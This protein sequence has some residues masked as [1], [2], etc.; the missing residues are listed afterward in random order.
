MAGGAQHDGAVWQGVR[1]MAMED[2]PRFRLRPYRNA[3]TRTERPDGH[4]H[5]AGQR[6]RLKTNQPF[7]TL[8]GSVNNYFN[9]STMRLQVRANSEARR[10]SRG[11]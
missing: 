10:R 8:P 5:T 11:G 4:G 9:H 3:A 1:V 6:R 2:Y 7:N